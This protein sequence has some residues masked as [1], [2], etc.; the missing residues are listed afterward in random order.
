MKYGIFGLFFQTVQLV[1]NATYHAFPLL[2]SYVL[3]LSP[4]ILAWK[5]LH[6]SRFFVDTNDGKTITENQVMV[7]GGRW[8][9]LVVVDG[10]W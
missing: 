9:S 6:C 1:N 2:H 5:D 3:G 7:V 10:R 8:W 4:L